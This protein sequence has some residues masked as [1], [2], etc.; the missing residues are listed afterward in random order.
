VL[1][2][3]SVT[4]ELAGFQKVTK[5]AIQVNINQSVRTTS[6]LAI[7]AATQ[8]VTVEAIATAIKTDDATVSE[9]IGTRAVA[10]LPLNG[11][12]P[13]RLP[14]MTPGVILGPKSSDT[15]TRRA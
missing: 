13:M 5:T 7:G 4:I 12:D 6:P 10:D 1:G 9:N 3:Y 15:G 2:W 11:R 8:T 14:L